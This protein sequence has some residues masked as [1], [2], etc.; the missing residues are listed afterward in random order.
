VQVCPK[1]IPLTESIAAAGREVTVQ[2]IKRF[3]SGR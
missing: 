3:F 2:S 1:E